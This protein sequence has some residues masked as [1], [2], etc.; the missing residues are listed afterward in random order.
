MVSTC[1]GGGK[2]GMSVSSVF[3]GNAAGCSGGASSVISLDGFFVTG[4]GAGLLNMLAQLRVPSGFRLGLAGS[5]AGVGLASEVLMFSHDESNAV[6]SAS[7]VWFQVPVAPSVAAPLPPSPAG[8]ASIDA[9]S[10]VVSRGPFGV[11]AP[12]P[13]RPRPRPRSEPRPRPRG[14]SLPPLPRP[15]RVVV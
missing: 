9:L 7:A 1:I 4:A 3:G 11:E 13:P 5:V 14:P 10:W 8:I 12:R 15:P 6:P 2:A